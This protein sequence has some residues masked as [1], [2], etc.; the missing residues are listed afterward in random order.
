MSA[1]RPK[2]EEG[3]VEGTHRVHLNIERWRV[4]E[5]WFGPAAAGVDSAGLEELMENILKGFPA[6]ERNRIVKVCAITKCYQPHG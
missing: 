4:P 3:D 1:F 6:E 5:T 2:Y